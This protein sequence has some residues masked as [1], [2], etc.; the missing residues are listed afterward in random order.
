MKC[1]QVIEKM[2]DF[3][4]DSVDGDT[5]AAMAG[6]FGDCPACREKL[7]QHDVMDRR[8]KRAMGGLRPSAGFAERVMENVA[9]MDASLVAGRPSFLISW[10]KP[11][12]MAASVL[13][14]LSGSAFLAWQR[15]AGGWLVRRLA[16][17]TNRSCRSRRPAVRLPSE[18][19]SWFITAPLSPTEG[20]PTFGSYERREAFRN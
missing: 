20:R 5:R 15:G 3:R 8:L 19:R 16:G 11:L 17:R 9:G 7:E 18:A 2:Q 1:G 10:M 12:L 4:E 6:H 14:V 13:A